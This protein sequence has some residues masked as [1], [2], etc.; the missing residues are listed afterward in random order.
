M[1]HV[2]KLSDYELQRGDPCGDISEDEGRHAKAI[3]PESKD[4]PEVSTTAVVKD[5][6][7]S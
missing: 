4:A 2:T 6:D 1:A 7:E 5:A 3:K